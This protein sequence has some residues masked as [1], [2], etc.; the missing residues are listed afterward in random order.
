[1]QEQTWHTFKYVWGIKLIWVPLLRD[2]NLRADLSKVCPGSEVVYA[3][4]HYHQELVEYGL[5]DVVS[6]GEENWD[7]IHFVFHL[8][9]V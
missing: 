8:V 1:M 6:C 3:V 9:A 5:L 2:W 7:H 4:R